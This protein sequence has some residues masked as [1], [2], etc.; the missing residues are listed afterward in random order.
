MER[1]VFLQKMFITGALI[2]NGRL[3]HSFFNV[4]DDKVVF[5]FTVASDGHYGEEGTPY[6]QYFATAVRRINE[7]HAQFP[8]K[9]IVVNGDVIHDDPK[10][11]QPAFQALKGLKPKLYV[12]QGNHDR[13]SP[14]VWHQTWGMPLNH[15]FSMG[16]RA[17]L[18]G[19]TSNE[20]GTYLCPDM[21]WFAESLEKYKKKKEVYIFIHITPKKWTR[22]GV[23]CPEFHELLAKYPNVRAVFNG[24]D[25]DHDDIKMSGNIPFMFDGR[26][27][28]NSRWG[29]TYRGFRVVEVLKNGD[30]RTYI[31]NPDEQILLEQLKKQQPA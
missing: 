2:T 29:T 24:H 31:M 5:R 11:L 18:L 16:N 26:F 10:F 8:S 4:A 21:S 3:A 27:G 20:K 6:E 19:T 7:H 9:F 1:R 13:V 17:F 23:D 22:Y 30:L 28:A 15:H 14:E 25:H 12:T